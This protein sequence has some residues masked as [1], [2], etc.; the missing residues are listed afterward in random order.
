MSVGLASLS[1]STGGILLCDFPVQSLTHKLRYAFVPDY[2]RKP[3]LMEMSR[4][5]DLSPLE[6]TDKDPA[7]QQWWCCFLSSGETHRKPPAP[8]RSHPKGGFCFVTEL[9]LTPT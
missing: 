7:L 4:D 1:V 5:T 2:L 8:S 3:F 9:L 6:S